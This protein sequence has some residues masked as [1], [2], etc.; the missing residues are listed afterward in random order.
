MHSQVEI[1]LLFWLIMNQYNPPARRQ[2]L[3]IVPW[4]ASCPSCRAPRL[5]VLAVERTLCVAG[6]LWKVT[7]GLQPAGKASMSTRK[8]R[9][10]LEQARIVKSCLNASWHVCIWVLEVA[11][12]HLHP[13]AASPIMQKVLHTPRMGQL[14]EHR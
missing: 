14:S 7:M 10:K 6:A 4:L 5:H 3:F 2:A 9:T 11:E 1:L 12:T 8:P 13:P